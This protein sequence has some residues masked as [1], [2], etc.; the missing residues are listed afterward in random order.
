MYKLLELVA[1]IFGRKSSVFSPCFFFFAKAVL[2]PF[3][4]ENWR[5]LYG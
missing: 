5:I 4:C 2:L 3:C 1:V